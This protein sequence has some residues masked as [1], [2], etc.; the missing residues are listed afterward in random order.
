MLSPSPE[1]GVIRGACGHYWYKHRGALA[2]PVCAE[3]A[4]LK[5][6]IARLTAAPK[7]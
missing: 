2:C 1:P 3:I 7:K 5:A 6:E 4:K